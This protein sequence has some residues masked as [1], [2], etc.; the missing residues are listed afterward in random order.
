MPLPHAT[1]PAD[2]PDDY[3]CDTLS[4]V[5]DRIRTVALNGLCSCTSTSCADQEMRSFVTIGPGVQ[6]PIGDSV[7]VHMNP[8]VPMAQAR[9]P[10][11]ALLGVAGYL[12]PFEV[13]LL[14]S[15]WPMIEADEATQ[16][17]YVPEADLVNGL[18][19]HSLAHGEKMYRALA[20]S[21][22]TQQM[23]VLPAN[24]HL[25]RVQ[26]GD[27]SPIPPSGGLVGWSTTVTVEVTF[28]A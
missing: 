25:G 6:D 3:C 22:Q 23:F 8:M 7:T 18:A 13:R 27:L 1:C 4:E 9:T 26:L 2:V 24:A 28:R 21:I 14:E 20:T 15:G 5:A 19:K 16:R 11:G 12:A 10:Q 17:I